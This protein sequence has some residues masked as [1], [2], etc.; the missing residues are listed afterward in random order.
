MISVH[1]KIHIY[2]YYI[3]LIIYLLF[4]NFCTL[5]IKITFCEMELGTKPFVLMIFVGEFFLL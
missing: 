5:I 4:E 3:Q 2:I 1:I